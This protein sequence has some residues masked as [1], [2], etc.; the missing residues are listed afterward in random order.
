MLDWVFNISQTMTEFFEYLLK[1]IIQDLSELFTML[2]SNSYDLFE[3]QV[4]KSIIEFFSKFVCLC[5]VL[6]CFFNIFLFHLF[7]VILCRSSRAV[8]FFC[9]FSFLFF[10][11]FFP[12]RISIMWTVI[13]IIIF[14]FFLSVF[15]FFKSF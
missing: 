13:I 7:R 9:F 15:H 14:S 2:D 10:P 8:S 5:F 1:A 12:H 3:L 11:L 6:F 4:V